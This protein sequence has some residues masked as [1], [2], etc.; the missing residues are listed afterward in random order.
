M[1]KQGEII[2]VNWHM[3]VEHDGIYTAKGTVI[4][5]SKRVGYVVEESI[6]ELSGGRKIRSKGFPSDLSGAQIER[7]A[8]ARIGKSYNLFGYNCQHFATECHG[9]KQSKQLRSTLWSI[10]GI[11]LIGILTKGRIWRV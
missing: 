5:G 4:S 7:N 3:G 11:A 10:A 9:S 6:E 2:S 1:Y 8:R